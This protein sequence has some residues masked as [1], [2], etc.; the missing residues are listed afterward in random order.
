MNHDFIQTPEGLK[1][2]FDSNGILCSQQKGIM[3]YVPEVDKWTTCS[4]EDF[5]LYYRG[6]TC[7]SCN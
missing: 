7:L 6:K 1:P 4:K 5:Q 3:D 2:R